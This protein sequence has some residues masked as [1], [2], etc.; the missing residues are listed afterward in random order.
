MGTVYNNLGSAHKARQPWLEALAW[1]RKSA[2]HNRAVAG[3]SAAVVGFTYYHL[4][5]VFLHTQR[6]DSARYYVEKSP[7]LRQ[8]L[9]EAEN[10]KQ[11]RELREKNLSQTPRSGKK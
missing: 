8:A 2:T 11:T 7:L 1:L 3:D 6:P 4:A 5:E 9:G 10:V